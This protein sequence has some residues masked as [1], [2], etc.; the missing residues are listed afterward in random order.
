MQIL[1]SF[2]ATSTKLWVASRISQ[3]TSCRLETA[4]GAG[5][6]PEASLAESTRS[7]RLAVNARWAARRVEEMA[8]DCEDLSNVPESRRSSLKLLMMVLVKPISFSFLL[9]LAASFNSVT[10]W[11]SC[12]MAMSH[13]ISELT[14]G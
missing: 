14:L 7:E 13:P 10:E 1:V 5:Q 4:S 3:I 6:I 9:L 11:S 2:V 8:R 12:L